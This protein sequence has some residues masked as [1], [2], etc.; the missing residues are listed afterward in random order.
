MGDGQVLAGPSAGDV[1]KCAINPLGCAVNAG[2][3]KIGET[4]SG[5]VGDALQKMVDGLIDG[6][7][8]TMTFVLTFWI[9]APTSG[10]TES[11]AVGGSITTMQD[12]VSTIT[13]FFG[14]LGL[15][16]AAGRMAWTA[17][18][19]PLKEMLRMLAAVVFVQALALSATQMLLRGGDEFSTWLIQTVTQQDMENSFV[20]LIPV[21]AANGGSFVA[22]PAT[23]QIALGAMMVVLIVVLLATIAQFMFLILRDVLLAIILV[24]LP[25]LAA[26]SL[27]KGGS[28]AFEKAQGWIVALL[29]YKPT[30]AIIYA[31]GVLLVKGVGSANEAGDVDWAA[32]L[33]GALT[34]VLATMAMPALIKFVA[35]AAGR[36]VS[37]AF[38]GGAAVA[39][40]VGAGAG[41]VAMG[42]S[43]AA[44]A[45]TGGASAPVSGA[46]MA[47]AGGGAGAGAGAAMGGSGAG[48]ATGAST[49][50]A[51]GSGPAAAGGA[52]EAAG[53]AGA[54]GAPGAGGASGSDGVGGASG[55]DGS[56][57]SSGSSGSS[58]SDG[59]GGTSGADGPSGAE[60]SGGSG[61]SSVGG[62][63]G[64]EASGSSSGSGDS[65][66]SSG[67]SGAQG[68]S[69]GSPPSGGGSGGS[70]SSPAK[71]RAEAVRDIAGAVQQESQG[72]SG[73]AIEEST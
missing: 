3:D 44:L 8:N 18:A 64:A 28:E 26:A 20:Q 5:A 53:G 31:L 69:V 54:G 14:I 62:A 71:D 41:A 60:G 35:P 21:I 10:L 30:A 51:A 27:T 42:A 48:A 68:A 9:T 33:L 19:E 40:A 25:T 17:R 72:P 56:G 63:T 43:V 37:N 73:S 11:S 32:L 66:S 58:G 1:A 24:F 49:G 45:A 55:S 52:G 4:V 38:S 29:L 6:I 59:S 61:G 23:I 12:Y 34:L 15:F 7:V 16:I 39:G 2:K 22:N 70:N 50:G 57:G 65:G 13:L 36:G 67:S 47:G 46:A